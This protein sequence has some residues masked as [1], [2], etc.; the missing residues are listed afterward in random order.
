MGIINVTPDSFSDGGKYFTKNSAVNH[1]ISL[2]KD[3][4]DILDIGGESSRPGAAP[5]SAKDELNRVLPVIKL[6]R[7]TD[8]AVL[9]SIDTTKSVV[10]KQ[11]VEAGADIVN[12]ISGFALDKNMPSVVSS[13]DV[14]VVLMHMKGKPATMQKNINY[15][16]FETSIINFFKKKCDTLNKLGH[17]NLILDP[18]F[19][20]GK[21]INQNFKLINMIPEIKKINSNILVGISRKSMIY[22]SIKSSPENSLN[23]TSVLNAVCILKG[24]SI[25]RVHD[26]KEAKEVIKMIN[27]VKNNN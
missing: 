7:K 18:G 8:S 22:K 19:G 3:G 12:D 10:A 14:P 25:L 26:V 11:A 24:A 23:S 15:T 6:I 9:I 21:T 13:L 5:I 20:F 16:N 17:T 27:L 2:I 4:A 1:A